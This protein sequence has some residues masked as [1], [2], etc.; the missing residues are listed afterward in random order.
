[1][2]DWL[3]QFGLARPPFALAPDPA[4]FHPAA[5]HGLALARL[6]EVLCGEGG[7]CLLT[8]EAGMGKTLL[9]RALVASLPVEFRVLWL[10]DPRVDEGGIVDA[11]LGALGGPAAASS[12]TARLAALEGAFRAARCG[13]R[14]VLLVVDEAQDLAP[15]VLEWLR[16]LVDLGAEGSRLLSVLL[17]GQPRLWRLLARPAL[18]PLRQRLA[19]RVHLAPLSRREVA[20]YLR[21]R[22]GVAGCRRPLFTR[23]AVAA[24]SQR[25]G[26]VPRLINQLAGRALIL[27]ARVGRRQVGRRWVARAASHLGPALVLPP[28][29]DRVRRR[30]RVAAALV[31]LAALAPA[32]GI[33]WRGEEASA[34]ARLAEARGLGAAP[35]TATALCRRAEVQ[36]WACAELPA[37]DPPPTSLVRL[38]QG[39]R[40]RWAFVAAKGEAGLLVA[41]AAGEHHLPWER[42]RRRVIGPAL[43]LWRPPPGYDGPLAP[44]ARNPRLVAWL[45]ERLKT[46]GLV[47]E[48]LIA[49][50]VYDAYLAAAVRRFQAARGLAPSG[51]LEPATLIALQEKAWPP[52]GR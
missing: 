3:R 52:A 28:G 13:G 50:G 8:G 7:L 47:E 39:R 33:W 48:G 51:I 2:S 49:G 45:A 35:S 30:R 38:R 31:L 22:L 29:L 6:R 4:F 19:A 42:Y 41:D 15:A 21:H 11:L 32:A 37:A 27:A 5:G 18:C 40:E 44:G 9:A 23:C 20:A 12:R 26:G 25:S 46:L 16:V 34:L 24:L 43:A 17:V 14:R 1:M 10:A 36:G